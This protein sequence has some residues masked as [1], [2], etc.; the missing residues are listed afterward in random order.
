MTVKQAF[1]SSTGRD[2]GAFRQ[3]VFEAVNGLDGWKCVRME[4]FGARARPIHVFD[5]EAIG[6]CQL[7]IGILGHR[8]GEIP[9]GHAASYTEQE[10]AAAL[11]LG[12]PRLMFLSAERPPGTQGTDE[13]EAKRRKQEAFRERVRQDQ[14]AG[15][16]STPA[17]LAAQVLKAIRNFERHEQR[18][19]HASGFADAAVIGGGLLAP[20]GSAGT[21]PAAV[22]RGLAAASAAYLDDLVGLLSGPTRFFVDRLRVSALTPARAFRFFLISML[23]F[24]VP[25]YLMLGRG[26]AAAAAGDFAKALLRSAMFLAAFLL[27]WRLVTERSYATT[28]TAMFL[29]QS[30]V[31]NVLYLITVLA[32]L[33][34]LALV[35]RTLAGALMQAI[36]AGN[37]WDFLVANAHRIAEFSP[38][39]IVDVIG[40]IVLLAWLVAMWASV[41]TVLRLSRSRAAA[42][43]AAFVAFGL[44]AFAA[45]A[46]VLQAAATFSAG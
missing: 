31:F 16:F 27:S 7:F 3:A 13:P 18:Y 9:D 20:T 32:G 11:A 6:R 21:A 29:H 25:L 10:Y 36:E 46:L 45:Y 39:L 24:A 2:L 42:A 34:A 28:L 4:D 19:E 38:Y 43:G 14:L 26:D 15:L 12:L 23:V 44:L 1:L 5:A 41:R 37:P 40:K 22:F 33:G 8:Y 17:E 35:D 30:A